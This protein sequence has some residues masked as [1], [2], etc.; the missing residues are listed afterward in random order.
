MENLEKFKYLLKVWRAMKET[1]EA[2][3]FR[4]D[5]TKI[6]SCVHFTTNIYIPLVFVGRIVPRRTRLFVY[7][8][9]DHIKAGI[10]PIIRANFK[11][12]TF[13]ILV[14]CGRLLDIECEG[15]SEV[16]VIADFFHISE[17]KRVFYSSVLSFVIVYPQLEGLN[18]VGFISSTFF[19]FGGKDIYY[20]Y[21]RENKPDNIHIAPFLV[22]HLKRF[23]L[24]VYENVSEE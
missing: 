17:L 7:S 5:A 6:M 21:E 2:M 23:M 13:S 8:L 22:P 19:S 4:E 10:Y 18:S 3:K 24:W 16:E 1:D 11:L 20:H 9:R 12:Q 15:F 14:P